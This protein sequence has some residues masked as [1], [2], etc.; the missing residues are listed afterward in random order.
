MRYTF[1]ECVLDTDRCELYR[2]GALVDL[3]PK[4]YEVLVYLVQHPERLVTQEELLRHVWPDVIVES[5]AIARNITAIRK[6]VGD[7]PKAPRVI[8]TL[9]RQGYRFVAPLTVQDTQALA[10]AAPQPPAGSPTLPHRFPL[11]GGRKR[12]G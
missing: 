1:A 12:L 5:G 11:T 6:A 2:A 9:H 8:K 7:H 10:I 4:P 3:E